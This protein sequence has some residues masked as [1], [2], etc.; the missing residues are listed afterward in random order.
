VIIVDNFAGSFKFQPDNGICIKSWYG[1]SEDKE[2]YELKEF[3]IGKLKRP[4]SEK[5]FKCEN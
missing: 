5:C 4:L 3:F 2:L 1:D